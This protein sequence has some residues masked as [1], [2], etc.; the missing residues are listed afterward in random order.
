MYARER[1]APSPVVDASS[2]AGSASSPGGDASSPG[3]DASPRRHLLVK[4]RCLDKQ[5]QYILLLPSWGID[6]QLGNADAGTRRP[7][8]R[9]R[10]PPGEDASPVYLY[11]YAWNNP[12]YVLQHKTQNFRPNYLFLQSR[13]RT[14]ALLLVPREKKFEKSFIL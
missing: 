13:E 10:P 12:I 6:P 5:I 3:G 11:I 2:P 14:F 7:Q 8:V 9:M 4:A 1:N